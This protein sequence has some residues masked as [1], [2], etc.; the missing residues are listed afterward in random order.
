L[1]HRVLTE[2]LHSDVS[3]VSSTSGVPHSSCDV[4]GMTCPND[5]SPR[6]NDLFSPKPQSPP[7]RSQTTGREVRGQADYQGGAHLKGPKA[8]PTIKLWGTGETWVATEVHDLF[9]SFDH[10]CHRRFITTLLFTSKSAVP[11]GTLSP[12]GRPTTDN[13]IG[14]VASGV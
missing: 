10:S 2:L 14:Q 4:F 9:R 1:L 12:Q 11:A 13:E 7:R 3:S 6:D 5:S 8:W